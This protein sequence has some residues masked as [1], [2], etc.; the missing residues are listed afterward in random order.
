VIE[1]ILHRDKFESAENIRMDIA[2][3]FNHLAP[4]MWQ[5]KWDANSVRLAA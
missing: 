2:L 1:K 5:E 4:G 3:N